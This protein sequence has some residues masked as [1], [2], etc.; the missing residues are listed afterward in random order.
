[1]DF[2]GRQIFK[3]PSWLTSDL[4]PV[5]LVLDGR[6]RCQSSRDVAQ[7]RRWRQAGLS[8][9]G[10]GLPRYAAGESVAMLIWLPRH[11]KSVPTQASI[12]SAGSSRSRSTAWS[13]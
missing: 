3:F 13:G 6:L 11:S 5:A 9:V 4:R 12:Q 1:M 8:Q 10:F 7:L 2:C